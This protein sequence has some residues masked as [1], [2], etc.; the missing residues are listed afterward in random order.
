MRIS[1][2][3]TARART[4]RIHGAARNEAGRESE[5]RLHQG[6][7]A[8]DARLAAAVQRV[9]AGFHVRQ[10]RDRRLGHAIRRDLGHGAQSGY[11]GAGADV[12]EREISCRN[13]INGWKPMGTAWRPMAGCAT[14]ASKRE[15][16]MEVFSPRY[17]HLYSARA[18][19]AVPAGGNAQSENHARRAPGR[20]TTSCGTRSR[21]FW[22]IR[23]RCER[24]VRDADREMAARAGNRSAPGGV[25]GR[26]SQRAQSQPLVYRALKIG[27]YKSEVTGAM[28][29]RISGGARRY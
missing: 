21:S 20:I 4:G 15:F 29:N 13:S 28:V 26:E 12:G 5:S 16:F 8:G 25:S 19:S 22:K 17:S 6:R 14:W 7:Y 3:F 11:G 10:S 27:P 1:A 23:R 24:A 9:D 2:R 18:E